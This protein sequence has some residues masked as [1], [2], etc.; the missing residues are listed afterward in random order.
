MDLFDIIHKPLCK[1]LCGL[2]YWKHG[3]RYG[4]NLPSTA[5]ESEGHEIGF[6]ILILM[7]TVVLYELSK[8]QIFAQ[9]LTITSPFLSP[10]FSPSIVPSFEF[11]VLPLLWASQVVLI[12]KNLPANAGDI[13][14]MGSIP[15][16]RGAGGDP[17]EE[18]RATHFSI[19]A[20]RIP[21]TEE[22]DRLQSTGL[23]S[24]TQL[25]RLSMHVP[26]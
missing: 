21:W 10:Y 22:P 18:S 11:S 20:W 23:Q 1:T 17:L 24:Q 16:E 13:R 12:I 26:L 7:L 4:P 15:E 5:S 3:D 2:C 6:H 19:L 25:K 9:M 8:D 14:D